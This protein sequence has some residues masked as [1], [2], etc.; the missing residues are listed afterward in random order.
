[1]QR[2]A[3]VV[4]IRQAFVVQFQLRKKRKKKKKKKRWE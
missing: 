2:D 4:D 3:A 1:M